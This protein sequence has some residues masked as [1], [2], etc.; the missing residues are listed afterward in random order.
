MFLAG[1]RLTD[2]FAVA[3]LLLL[4]VAAVCLGQVADAASRK[5]GAF[6]ILSRKLSS[7]LVEGVNLTINYEIHN[8]GMS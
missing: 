7:D 4:C 1:R 2:R 6:L 3:D 8:V 5:E